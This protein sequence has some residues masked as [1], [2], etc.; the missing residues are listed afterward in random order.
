MLRDLNKP[1]A[2]LSE[3]KLD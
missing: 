1:I 2:C 3:H